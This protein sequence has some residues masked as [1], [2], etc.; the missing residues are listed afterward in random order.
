MNNHFSLN[1]TNRSALAGFSFA[2]WQYKQTRGTAVKLKAPQPGSW[3]SWN[4]SCHVIIQM[5]P[6]GGRESDFHLLFL[7]IV[8][9]GNLGPRV[10]WPALSRVWGCKTSDWQDVDSSTVKPTKKASS[11]TES[12][13][14]LTWGHTAGW[15]RTCRGQRK[16]T[17]T[18]EGQEHKL[19][20]ADR[21]WWF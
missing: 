6:A 17:R 15:Q 13:V 5:K 3:S 12:H 8:S 1:K 4:R 7:W 21:K 11:E 18:A 9:C 2:L 14:R 20:H 19:R 10:A 16:D